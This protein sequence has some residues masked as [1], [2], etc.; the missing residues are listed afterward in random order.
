M[1]DITYHFS[2][3][4]LFPKQ[5][6][7]LLK[8][9]GVSELDMCSLALPSIILDLEL[10]CTHS[11][12]LDAPNQQHNCSSCLHPLLAEVAVS[13]HLLDDLSICIPK[14]AIGLARIQSLG[15]FRYIL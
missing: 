15:E 6:D 2:P 7:V 4:V 10:P 14:I 3:F 8:K 12:Q 11:D 5:P 13:E 1:F 9:F